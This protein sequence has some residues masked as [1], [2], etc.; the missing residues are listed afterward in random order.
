[1]A[2]EITA[3]LLL[4]IHGLHQEDIE[5]ALIYRMILSLGKS[6]TER[7]CIAVTLKIN[8]IQPVNWFLGFTNSAMK[9]LLLP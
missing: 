3:I 2:F 4:G 5:L 6:A 1:L 7:T 8:V 9:S